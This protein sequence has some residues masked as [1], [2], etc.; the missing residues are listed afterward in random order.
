MRKIQS[1]A[2]M[3]ASLYR[4]FIA[5]DKLCSSEHTM[6]EHKVSMGLFLRFLKERYHIN[7]ENFTREVFERERLEEFVDWTI[8]IR[9]CS[10]ATANIRLSSLRAFIRY[11]AM[12]DASYHWLYLSST[13]IKR[14]RDEK[15]RYV[16][17]LSEAAVQCLLHTPDITTESGLKYVTLMSMLYTTATRLNEILSLKVS[18]LQLDKTPAYV[19]VLGKGRKSRVVYFPPKLVA[20]LR[21][22]IARFHVK[23]EEECYLFYSK[24]RDAYSKLSE[25]GVNKQLKKYAKL[26]HD[27]CPEVPLTLHS[28][29]FRHSCA[30]HALEHHMSVFQI[31]KMLG[32]SSVDTTMTY[33]GITP[34]M[35]EEAMLKIEKLYDTNAPKIKPQWLGKGKDIAA[36]FEL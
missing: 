1:D 11:I 9:H 15:L 31:S 2:Y 33:L 30:T 23:G 36:L 7:I 14:R 32:H 34:K 3:I 21:K 29:Q 4:D 6:K 28:H 16:E 27:V 22:Y 5:E 18:D 19:K 35:R 10:P 8:S 25:E 17:P 26:A 13:S 24:Q 20:L 12:K